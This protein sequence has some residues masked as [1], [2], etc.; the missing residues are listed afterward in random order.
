MYELL[1]FD[2][3]YSIEHRWIFSRPLSKTEM[4]KVISEYDN[5]RYKN[6]EIYGDEKLTEFSCTIS[7]L[8]YLD[9]YSFQFDDYILEKEWEFTY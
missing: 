4:M 5:K 8:V 9:F 3:G 1:L 6:D 7:P 2:K